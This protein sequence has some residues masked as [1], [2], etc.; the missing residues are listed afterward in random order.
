MWHS[1][2]RR[3]G[4]QG[5]RTR[6]CSSTARTSGRDPAEIERTWGVQADVLEHADA[7]VDAGVQHLIV[8]IGGDGEGYD[9]AVLR[10][11]VAWRDAR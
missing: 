8:G 11:L 6:S 7:L 10:E 2:R 4:V 1:L 5:A 9:L 3:R